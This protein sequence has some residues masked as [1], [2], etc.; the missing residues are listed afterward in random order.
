MSMK[1]R[2][3]LVLAAAVALSGCMSEYK[4]APLPASPGQKAAT[5]PPSPS[6]SGSGAAAA[7]KMPIQLST[8]VALAQTL[9]DGTAVL[10]SIDY[11]FLGEEP[12]ASTQ[13]IW[14]IERA[15]GKPGRI[16]VQLEKKGTLQTVSPWRPEEGPFQG[17]IEDGSGNRLS[18][19]IDLR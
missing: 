1:T 4:P 2:R 10:F 17:H 18:P 15:R 19:T 16:V 7:P 12:Q 11:Q 3:F 9:P 14:V 5:P 8:G 6:P 13:Y